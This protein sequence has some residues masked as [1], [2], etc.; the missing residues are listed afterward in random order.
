[1][2]RLAW[3]NLGFRFWELLLNYGRDPFAFTR[4]PI[5]AGSYDEHQINAPLLICAQCGKKFY[6][7]QITQD[8]QGWICLICRQKASH[9]S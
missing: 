8:R 2:L 7:T 5:F 4:S 6:S 3:Q 1:M 9:A